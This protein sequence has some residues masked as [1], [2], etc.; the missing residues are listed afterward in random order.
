MNLN[1]LNKF[2]GFLK[3]FPGVSPDRAVPLPRLFLG[4]TAQSFDL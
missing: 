1:I 3:L 2:A 4:G